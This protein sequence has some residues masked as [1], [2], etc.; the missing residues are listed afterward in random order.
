MP[1]QRHDES[2]YVMLLASL[3]ADTLD[4]KSHSIDYVRRWPFLEQEHGV[5]HVWARPQYRRQTSHVSALSHDLVSGF[6]LIA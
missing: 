5:I 6:E 3:F 1:K 4:A 2:V